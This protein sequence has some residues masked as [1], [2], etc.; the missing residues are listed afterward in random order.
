MEFLRQLSLILMLINIYSTLYIAV[1][2]LNGGLG[3][4]R[5][6]LPLITGQPLLELDRTDPQKL[7]TTVSG[8]LFHPRI[9]RHVNANPIQFL[10]VTL[11]I[12]AISTDNLKLF[13][14]SS[15]PT[16]SRIALRNPLGI[17]VFPVTGVFR[18]DCRVPVSEN[19]AMWPRSCP[20]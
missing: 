13:L 14:R 1:T 15:S 4:A 10:P 17:P 8:S 20:V 6:G 5:P 7:S 16:S 2:A 12:A 3:P 18:E 19:R 11:T 9:C